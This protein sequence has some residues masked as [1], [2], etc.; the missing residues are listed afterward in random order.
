LKEEGLRSSKVR[1][2]ILIRIGWLDEFL[3]Q[4]EVGIRNELDGIVDEVVREF[5][6]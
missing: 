5:Q 3:E 4:Y 6:Y 1:G 2:T